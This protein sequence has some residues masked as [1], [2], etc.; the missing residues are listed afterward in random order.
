MQVL[1]AFETKSD[2]AIKTLL[3]GN[4]F[5]PQMKKGE[6]LLNA[7]HGK[8]EINPRTDQYYNIV[9]Y[10][11]PKSSCIDLV[12]NSRQIYTKVENTNGKIVETKKYRRD[13]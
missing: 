2:N 13:Y 9:L 8:M 5:P 3:D 7:W 10:S 4:N 6:M 12:S 11:V 1:S